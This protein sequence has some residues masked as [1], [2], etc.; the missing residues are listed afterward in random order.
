MGKQRLAV[1]S[2]KRYVNVIDDGVSGQLTDCV[3]ASPRSEQNKQDTN[4]AESLF[5]QANSCIGTTVLSGR[6]RTTVMFSSD[7]SDASLV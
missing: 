5:K 7:P 3:L 6:G 2:V 1:V 4:R